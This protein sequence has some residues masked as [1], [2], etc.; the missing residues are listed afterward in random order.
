LEKISLH[1]L[2]FGDTQNRFFLMTYY[3]VGVAYFVMFYKVLLAVLKHPVY[4]IN[5]TENPF[6]YQFCTNKIKNN[7]HK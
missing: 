3:S 6:F 5:L 4:C 7:T 1:S 2:S